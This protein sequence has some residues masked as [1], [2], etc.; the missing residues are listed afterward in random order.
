MTI[1][2]E[3]I[4]SFQLFDNTITI[5]YDPNL[6]RNKDIVGE[7]SYRKQIITLQTPCDTHTYQALRTTFWHEFFHM[8]C[9]NLGYSNLAKDEQLMELLARATSQCLKTLETKPGEVAVG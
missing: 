3:N 5:D 6:S 1:D 2:Y 8:A 9:E 4:E 7:A